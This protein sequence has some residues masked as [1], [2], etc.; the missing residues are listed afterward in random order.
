[1]A[2]WFE[3]VCEIMLSEASDLKD[4]A[5]IAG[6]DPRYFYCGANLNGADL[7]G[8][9]LIGME[10]HGASLND[11]KV[12]AHTKADWP[13]LRQL[14]ENEKWTKTREDELVTLWRSGFSAAAIARQMN[15]WSR[16]EIIDRAHKLKL[17]GRSLGST[18][19][20]FDGERVRP[21]RL[22]N[23]GYVL[24]KLNLRIKQTSQLF[25]TINEWIAFFSNRPREVRL[26]RRALEVLSDRKILLVE[27]QGPDAVQTLREAINDTHKSRS[28]LSRCLY[29]SYDRRHAEM[30][31]S[32]A[33]G[34]S[35]RIAS[36]A[37][38]PT[39]AR[40]KI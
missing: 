16:H 13:Q 32:M 7:R 12:D 24:E 19:A 5:R 38:K 3:R 26:P 33:F 37:R 29:C 1:M 2:K 10:F 23:L 30:D 25:W 21:P 6:S 17:S 9:D 11:V 39:R 18:L 28:I 8:M 34:R 20:I 36:A 31:L 4:L 14:V 15:V 40:S 22:G 27:V 35:V